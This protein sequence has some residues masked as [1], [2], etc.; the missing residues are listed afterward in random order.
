MNRNR[1]QRRSDK[2]QIFKEM[3][4]LAWSALVRVDYRHMPRNSV[5]AGVCRVWQNAQYIVQEYVH[6]TDWGIVTQLMIR[7]NDEKPVHDWAVF[8]RIKNELFGPESVAIEIYPATSELV[9][10]CN[11]YHLWILPAGFRI[12]FT[13]ANMKAT[14]IQSNANADEGKADS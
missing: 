5:P 8:Q 9:D 12:P 10:K 3:K 1:E 7:P 6:R 14:M 4:T 2:R 11:I 13:L